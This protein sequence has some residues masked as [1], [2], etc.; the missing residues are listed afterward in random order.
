[1]CNNI[2]CDNR[3]AEIHYLDMIMLVIIVIY[4]HRLACYLNLAVLKIGAFVGLCG[5]YCPYCM[6]V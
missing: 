4:V 1:M 2:K 6:Y 5:N 3:I